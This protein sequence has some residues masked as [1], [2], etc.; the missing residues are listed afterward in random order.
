MKLV[1]V[2]E[3]VWGALTAFLVAWAVLTV[4]GSNVAWFMAGV[5]IAVGLSNVANATKAR[6]EADRR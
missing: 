1:S 6:K 4:N 3:V 5:G 2:A